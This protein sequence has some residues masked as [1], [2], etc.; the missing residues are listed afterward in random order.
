MAEKSFATNVAKIAGIPN[1]VIINAKKMEEKITKEESK[2][3]R[4]RDIL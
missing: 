4:N 2:I 1:E 3:N